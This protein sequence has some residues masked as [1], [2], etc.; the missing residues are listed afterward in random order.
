MKI[1]LVFSLLLFVH[2]GFSQEPFFKVSQPFVFTNGKIGGAYIDIDMVENDAW[3]V[4]SGGSSPTYGHYYN[5][6]GKKVPA[7]LK[8]NGSANHLYVKSSEEYL[9]GKVL[10]AGKECKGFV[11]EN[12]SFTVFNN[13]TFN[14]VTKSKELNKPQFVKYIASIDGH[15]LFRHIRTTKDARWVTY[16]LKDTK[17]DRI[18]TLPNEDEELRRALEC[19][20]HVAPELKS[21]IGGFGYTVQ[22]MEEIFTYLK[23]KKCYVADSVMFLNSSLNAVEDSLQ[24]SC[25]LKVNHISHE[26]SELEYYSL[27]RRKLMTATYSTLFPKVK[28][29]QC[30]YYYPNG[31][32][33][34]KVEYKDGRIQCL[35]AVYYQTGEPKVTIINYPKAYRYRLESLNA[36]KDT[37]GLKSFIN[38]VKALQHDVWS[39]GTEVLY[40]EWKD[41]F[42]ANL[43]DETGSGLIQEVDSTNSMVYHRV[44]S[45]YQLMEAYY[46]LGDKKIYQYCESPLKLR[47]F[48][49]KGAEFSKGFGYPIKWKVN[50]MAG[51]CLV[52]FVIDGDGLI[53][54]YAIERI[55]DEDTSQ[56]M[57]VFLKRIIGDTSWRVAK[58]KQ[59]KVMGEYWL[60]INFIDRFDNLSSGRYHNSG[61]M[62]MQQMQMQQM[63]NNFRPPV[64]F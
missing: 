11:I 20:Y 36:L 22:D 57:D 49:N 2:F 44:I 43:L 53:K 52:R 60:C 59:E 9:K 45:N 19:F 30:T 39:K 50:E 5:A 63:Q 24:A 51:C 29:G 32:V 33:R 7:Y 14:K 31:N 12:D 62:Q 25:Y 38:E 54:H 47:D 58:N 61:L 34:K 21:L 48:N 13:V 16:L 8:Y 3:Y 40:Y 1:R 10:S 64:G 55:L 46:L 27:D 42:G 26:A 35:E 17:A 4:Y 18:I 15:E 23:Y 6:E 41:R 56:K 37:N 28:H